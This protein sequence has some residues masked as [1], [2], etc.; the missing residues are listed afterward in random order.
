MRKKNKRKIGPKMEIIF[1]LALMISILVAMAWAGY[2]D[3]EDEV[4]MEE[5]YGNYWD[6]EAKKMK[7]YVVYVD[8]RGFIKTIGEFDFSTTKVL[9][10]SLRFDNDGIEKFYDKF[11]GEGVNFH[12]FEY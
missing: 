4:L 2:Y 7:D 12:I 9:E 10:E 6:N 1:G 3:Y 5:F 8:N 11:F